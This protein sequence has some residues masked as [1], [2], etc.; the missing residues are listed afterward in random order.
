MKKNKFYF[1]FLGYYKSIV[2]LDSLFYRQHVYEKSLEWWGLHTNRLA[3][4]K[5]YE[6]SVIS[7]TRNYSR[8]LSL[9]AMETFQ[10]RDFF[11]QISANEVSFVNRK[12]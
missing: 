6:I 1:M 9:S 11:D 8:T 5:I 2:D 3:V 10:F 7:L 12:G 4:A